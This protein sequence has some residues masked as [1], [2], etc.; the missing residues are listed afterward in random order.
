VLE[1][2]LDIDELFAPGNDPALRTYLRLLH[3]ADTAQL[4]NYVEHDQWTRITS[5]LAPETLAE[6]MTHLDEPQREALGEA[7]STQRLIDV[8][9]ELE[10]DDAADLLADLP[11]EK[12]VVILPELED[13]AKIRTL[14]QF[15]EDSAGGIMQ[16]ELC[17]VRSS[18]CVADAIEAVR[19]TREQ[20]EDIYLVYVVDDQGKLEGSVALADLVLSKGD[21][22]ITRAMRPVERTVTAEV[23]QEEVAQLFKKYDLA[24]LAVVDKDGKLLGRITF[25]DVHDVLEE[26]AS[27][28]MMALA[29][30]SVEELVYGPEVFRI[31]MFRLPWLI[32]SLVGSL[33][34]AHIVMQFSHVPGNAILLAAFVP[35]IN[36]M[37]GNVGSQSAMII[38]RGFAIGKVDFAQLGRTIGREL[39]VGGIM[40]VAAGAVVGAVG[41]FWNG[42]PILGVALALAM[43]CSMSAAT[44]VGVG[45]P[46]LFRRAGIDPAIAAGPLVTTSCDVIGASIYLLVAIAV[47]GSK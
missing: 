37:T 47:L 11:D 29:G 30:A 31:A 8:V 1:H 18:A 38:T 4:F 25:D 15:P 28:D 34:T 32:S 14:L 39:R 12:A 45:A 26:E 20:T 33:I 46:S 43:V 41:H 9:D 2:D 6:V 17:R 40:G 10:T 7:L 36:A 44:I 23:D 22:P 35:V 16:T 19:R 5:M 13:H 21:A 3:P 24:T 42:S 27:E